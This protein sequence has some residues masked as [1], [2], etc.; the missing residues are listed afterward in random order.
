MHSKQQNSKIFLCYFLLSKFNAATE[1]IDLNQ[2]HSG[3]K[4]SEELPQAS[5]LAGLMCRVSSTHCW[6]PATQ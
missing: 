1:V 5:A 2:L 6:L 3:Q 4:Q